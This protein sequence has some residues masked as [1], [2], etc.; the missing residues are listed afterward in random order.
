[1]ELTDHISEAHQRQDRRDKGKGQLTLINVYGPTSVNT[2]RE[3][4]L[5]SAFYSQ[6]QAVYSAEKEKSA[7]VFIMGDFNSK[8]GVRAYCPLYK[9]F[10]Q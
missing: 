6:V 9:T 7:L 10:V 8:I 3:P 4:E 5:G 2:A 1:M